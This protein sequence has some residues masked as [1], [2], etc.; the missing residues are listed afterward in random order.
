VLLRRFA[1]RCEAVTARVIGPGGETLAAFARDGGDPTSSAYE[2]RWQSV[3]LA[4]IRDGRAELASDNDEAAEVELC[5]PIESPGANSALYATFGPDALGQAPTILWNATSFA[6][7]LALC[8]D[9][10]AGF[11][12][13]VGGAVLDPL[14]GCLNAAALW[15]TLESE[16]KRATRQHTPLSCAH[17]DIDDF[18]LVNEDVGYDG[19]DVLLAAVGAALSVA[20]RGYDSVAR[21]GADDF[22]IVMPNSTEKQ[23]NALAHRIEQQ[24]IAATAPLAEQP[25]SAAFGVAQWRFE[26][27]AASLVERASGRPAAPSVPDA[28]SL[29]AGSRTSGTPLEP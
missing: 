19:G 9:D 18:G 3:A 24:L 16:I 27:S 6:H 2:R 13:L 29:G 17:M 5:V 12:R 10:P 22:V 21:V 20:I 4:V 26:E 14:T 15:E 8:L 7:A 28:S 1:I 11:G 23:A 25:L